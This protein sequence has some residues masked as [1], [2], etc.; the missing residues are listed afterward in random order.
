MIKTI[1]Q[2]EITDFCWVPENLVT[3]SV[4]W[5]YYFFLIFSTVISEQ[6]SLEPARILHFLTIVFYNKYQK[7]ATL[8]LTFTKVK[9][10]QNRTFVAPR[11]ISSISV[12]TLGKLNLYFVASIRII[13]TIIIDTSDAR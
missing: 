12:L 5:T 3:Q 11:Y 4:I 1:T 8:S 6:N 7:N 9:T 10:Q 2:H 13:K